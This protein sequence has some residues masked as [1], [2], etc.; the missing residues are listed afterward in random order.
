MFLP[1]LFLQSS[2]GCVEEEADGEPEGGNVSGKFSSGHKRTDSEFT[3]T[4]AAS[5]SSSTKGMKWTLGP[6]PKH[7]AIYNGHRL[8]PCHQQ[9]QFSP[10]VSLSISTKPS[11][12][13]PGAVG[14]PSRSAEHNS[15]LFL[16][17]LS[18]RFVWHYLFH[19]SFPCLF[20]LGEGPGSCFLLFLF[21]FCLFVCFWEM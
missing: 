12:P 20:W 16:W 9:N 5:T 19:W 18:F 1:K 14:Q 11:G 4:V 17:A 7:E 3:E 15:V 21:A 6:I 13:A 8:S 10:I 2:G